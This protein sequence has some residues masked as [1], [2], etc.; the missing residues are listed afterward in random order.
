MILYIL[1]VKR[2]SKRKEVKNFHSKVLAKYFLLN[3][4]VKEKN[5]SCIQMNKKNCK[6]EKVQG[7]YKRPRGF[8]ENK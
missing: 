5:H 6:E 8:S 4:K 7:S 1:T 2:V 3:K